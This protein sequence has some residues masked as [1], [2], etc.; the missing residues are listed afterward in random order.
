MKAHART[1]ALGWLALA[2]LLWL[3]FAAIFVPLH[4]RA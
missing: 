4:V 1:R 3:V 2:A